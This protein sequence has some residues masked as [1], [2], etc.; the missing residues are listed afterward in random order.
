MFRFLFVFAALL[1]CVQ[2]K[3]YHFGINY[4]GYS[5]ARLKTAIETAPFLAYLGEK[6]ALDFE[7]RTYK[8]DAE[9]FYA[10]KSGAADI[11]Y[12]DAIAYISARRQMTNIEPIAITLSAD[13][14]PN[15]MCA[16]ARIEREDISFY[17]DQK[18]AAYATRD[19]LCRA[20][21]AIENMEAIEKINASDAIF[22]LLIGEAD[23]IWTTTETI[24]RYAHLHLIAAPQKEQFPN[25]VLV[26]NTSTMTERD[27]QKILEAIM[28][29][30]RDEIDRSI[31]A[32]KFRFGFKEI[33]DMYFNTF[34]EK[35]RNAGLF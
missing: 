3:S 28:G 31:W 4:G 13:L 9:L 7:L 27:R 10:L 29:V 11:V 22:S 18:R 25:G 30:E 15:L 14:S 12:M 26:R 16:I 2:A 32:Y 8:N 5:S 19:S 23:A 17:H 35:L 6:T 34:R 1:L 21:T 24:A 33:N 20:K